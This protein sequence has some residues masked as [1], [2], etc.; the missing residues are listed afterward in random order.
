MTVD[1]VNY[2][3]NSNLKI[4]LKEMK[5]YI[6]IIWKNYQ[7]LDSLDSGNLEDLSKILAGF[8]SEVGY[9]LLDE[10][11]YRPDPPIHIL[12]NE[13]KKLLSHFYGIH[14]SNDSKKES[15]QNN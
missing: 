12:S 13:S 10:L 5:K 15:T 4:F 11:F 6:Q 7:G 9:I 2:L 1:N 3:N 8:P 14:L